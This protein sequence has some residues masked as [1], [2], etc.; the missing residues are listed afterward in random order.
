MESRYFIVFYMLFEVRVAIYLPLSAT[1]VTKGVFPNQAKAISMLVEN[2][3][4]EGT[5]VDP[6]CISITNIIELPEADYQEFI[7]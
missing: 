7:K 3:R 2:H 6:V 4:A 5:E 1:A